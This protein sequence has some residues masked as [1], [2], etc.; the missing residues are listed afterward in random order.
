MKHPR[1]RLE[2]LKKLLAHMRNSEGRRHTEF[3]FAT[4]CSWA[5]GNLG[6]AQGKAKPYCG[7]AGCMGGELPGLFPRHWEWGGDNR[8][9]LKVHPCL[10][11][12]GDLSAFFSLTDNEVRHLF[13]PLGQD[14]DSFG[15]EDLPSHATADEVA[16]N[17]EIFIRR[18]GGFI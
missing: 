15:G 18:A 1:I 12:A 3:S 17:L 14:T 10:T 6:N 5:L 16:D 13:Y 9:R 11:P 4:F 2:R 7:T 8:P